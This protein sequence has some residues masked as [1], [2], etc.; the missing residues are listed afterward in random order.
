[1]KPEVAA[2]LQAVGLEPSAV[3][4]VVET[5]LVEDVGSGDV[6]SSATVPADR[7]DVAG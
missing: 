5:A 3:A 4:T 1:M 7:D 6:T 2:A